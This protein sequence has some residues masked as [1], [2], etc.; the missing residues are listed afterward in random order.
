M[1]IAELCAGYGGLFLALRHA[2]PDVELAWYAEIDHGDVTCIDW[3]KTESVDVLTAGF[4]C[5]AIIKIYNELK[6]S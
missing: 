2:Q 4:P 6:E 3:G 5:L 1:K